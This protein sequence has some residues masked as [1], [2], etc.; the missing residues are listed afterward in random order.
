[1]LLN[2]VPLATS[3]GLALPVVDPFPSWP[4]SL[5]PQQDTVPDLDNEH[6]CAPPAVII[7]SIV[8]FGAVESPQ[9]PAEMARTANRK[10]EGLRFISATN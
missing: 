2:F 1:M 3:T 6:V 5:F 9:A 10:A 7:G 8:W 4:K